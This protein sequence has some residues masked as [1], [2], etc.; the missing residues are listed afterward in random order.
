MRSTCKVARGS[1]VP[2]ECAARALAGLGALAGL[3]RQGPRD[4]LKCE[5]CSVAGW[6]G[7][8]GG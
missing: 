3:C 7:G 2:E 8:G 1:G 6:L 4:E 5:G